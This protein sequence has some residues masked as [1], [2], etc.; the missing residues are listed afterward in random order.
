MSVISEQYRALLPSLGSAGLVAVSKTF[1]ASDIQEIY[2]CGQRSFGESR[3]SELA[4]KVK[5]LPADI[6]W[7]FIGHLQSNKVKAVVEYS[8]WIHAVDSLKLLERIDRIA[9]ELGKRP[10]LLLE[11]NVSG[12]ESKFGLRPEELAELLAFKPEH[13]EVVG[14]MTM[15]P[16]G[17]PEPELRRIF[18][19]LAGL[20]KSVGLPELS[21]GMSGDYPIAVECGATMVRVGSAIFGRREYLK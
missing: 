17:A 3:A 10:K 5:S 18:T 20:A 11:V 2:D 4:E 16:D 21:M 19:T 7:H 14:L 9:G 12:E 13:C 8:S 15:A 6:E 1:P